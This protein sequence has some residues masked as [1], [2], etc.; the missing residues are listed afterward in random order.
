MSQDEETKEKIL[1][2][3]DMSE[4]SQKELSLLIRKVCPIPYMQN[5]TVFVSK[6]K[7]VIHK[8]KKGNVLFY[9]QQIKKLRNWFQFVHVSVFDLAS[10]M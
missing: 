5:P 7:I 10:M 4:F 8:D 2:S 9:P 3:L 1:P 6:D